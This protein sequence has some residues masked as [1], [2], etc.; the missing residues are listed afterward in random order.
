MSD[1]KL[2]E[3][4]VRIAIKLIKQSEGCYLKAYAD[5][6]SEL[7]RAIQGKGLWSLYLEGKWS[8]PE[9]WK[10]LKGIPYT[11]GYGET[12]GIIK[13]TVLTQEE[14]DT[15]LDKRVR[16]FFQEVFEATPAL[17][18][19][20]PEKQAA[21]ISLVYNIGITNYKKYD[22]SKQV[23]AGNHEMVVKKFNQYVYA[24][25]TI[26]QGLVN[27]RKREADLYASVKG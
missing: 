24:N 17:A 23:Q 21:V 19:Y 5:P 16:Q 12:Q 22:I 4:A 7:A 6:A 2:N 25:G 18:T 9:E 27:R 14:A 3:V 26:N 11:A 20:S 1:F 10:H 13:S 15:K 8:V